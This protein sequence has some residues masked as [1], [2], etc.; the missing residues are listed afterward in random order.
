M[1]TKA[2]ESL[3]T[4]ETVSQDTVSGEVEEPIQDKNLR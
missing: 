3:I 1:K 4:S 2:V